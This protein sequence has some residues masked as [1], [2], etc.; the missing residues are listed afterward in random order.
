MGHF[1]RAITH[2]AY[3]HVSVSLDEDLS[4]M[5]SFARLKR[6]TPFCGGFVR[7]GAER[8]RNGKQIATI[9]VCGVEIGEEAADKVRLSIQVMNEHPENYI[10]NM[11]SA[12][13]VPWRKTVSVRDAY[14]CVEFIVSILNLAGIQL[15]HEC[16]SAG[17]L[18]AQLYD[19]EVY[20]GVYPDRTVVADESYCDRVSIS[21]R[22]TLSVKQIWRLIHRLVSH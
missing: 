13:L 11:L 4:D 18:Y 2:S 20:Q 15:S 22:I 9:S 8:Y 12:L 5:Y 3:N 6:D 19:C 14:T 17:E 7:E 21:H 10:Y 1:I 16:Y